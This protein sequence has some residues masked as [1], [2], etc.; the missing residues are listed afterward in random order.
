MAGDP[1]GAFSIKADRDLRTRVCDVLAQRT[2]NTMKIGMARQMSASTTGPTGGVSMTM[3][4]NDGGRRDNLREPL[5]HDKV[6]RRHIGHAIADDH[7]EIAERIRDR[8]LRNGLR[9]LRALQQ[10]GKHELLSTPRRLL[11]LGLRKSQSIS[12]VFLRTLQRA[13]ER[14][15]DCRFALI[16]LRGGNQHNTHSRRSDP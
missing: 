7:G 5:T 16:R 14:Q 1:F 13:A 11:M 10:V 4:R 3:Y 12:S 8:L 15:R 6:I 2:T 9:S